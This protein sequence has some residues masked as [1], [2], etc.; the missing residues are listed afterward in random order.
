MVKKQLK[1]I[2]FTRFF[3]L[4][5]LVFG[6]FSSCSFEAEKAGGVLAFEGGKDVT[7]NLEDGY[8]Q[9]KLS[10]SVSGIVTYDSAN[11]TVADAGR[12]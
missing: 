8:Y 1:K 3:V 2:S 9:I 6:M 11:K 10:R 4:C 12:D 7:V 5:T